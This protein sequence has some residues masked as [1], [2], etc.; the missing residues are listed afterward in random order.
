MQ[1]WALLILSPCLY[2]QSFSKKREALKCNY[3]LNSWCQIR[4]LEFCLWNT[5]LKEL[6][7]L[8][9]MLTA[10]LFERTPLQIIP[11][12]FTEISS[13]ISYN[14]CYKEHVSINW[15]SVKSMFQ[16]ISEIIE[17][18]TYKSWSLTVT[19]V[20]ALYFWTLNLVSSSFNANIEDA[21][22]DPFNWTDLNT[23]FLD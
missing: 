16:V 6:I 13:S 20:L 7:A 9:T 4:L 22:I 11:S 12:G 3:N 17:R 14:L 10:A 15:R 23:L 5:P 2:K 21:F 8:L 1:G 18:G 19:S